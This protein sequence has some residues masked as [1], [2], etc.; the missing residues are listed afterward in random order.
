MSDPLEDLVLNG[1]AEARRTAAELPG[2]EHSRR[3]PQDDI[4]EEGEDRDFDE[5]DAEEEVGGPLA[6]EQRDEM[7][8]EGGGRGH[9]TGPKGVIRD[10]KDRAA[11]DARSHADRI[12]STNAALRKMALTANTVDEDERLQKKEAKASARRREKSP[13]RQ[14]TGRKGDSEDEEDGGEKG[15]ANGEDRVDPAAA[16]EFAARERRRA[17][18]L[19]E[20]QREADRKRARLL[21]TGFSPAPDPPAQ[22][23]DVWFG[24]LRE[25][26]ALGYV[27]ATDDEREDVPVVVH[28]YEKSVPACCILTSAL[29]SLARQYPH[30]KFIQV[31]ARTVGF[32]L[33]DDEIAQDEDEDEDEA[34][35]RAKEEA[36]LAKVGPVL[37]TLHIYLGGELRANLVRVDLG[38]DWK[39]GKETAIRGILQHHRAILDLRGASE[40]RGTRAVTSNQDSDSDFD[41]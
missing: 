22:R 9:N 4:V 21:G 25:V 31:R 33:S 37:P 1:G 20:L 32:G 28:I 3:G 11:A 29:T 27:R 39:G 30:T 8:R 7:P 41:D 24:H 5:Q 35:V 17:Q 15:V 26:D 23:A 19:E 14:R 13:D 38:D 18:R 2:I 16:A 34:Q 40:G 36:L 10:Q 12:R 6:D